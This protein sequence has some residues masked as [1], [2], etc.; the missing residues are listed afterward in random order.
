MCLNLRPY[1]DRRRAARAERK[2]KKKKKEK[3]KRKKKKRKKQ[4]CVVKFRSGQSN[5]EAER[6][7]KK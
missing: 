3:K 1:A 6:V 4:N 5:S 7:Q 2:K